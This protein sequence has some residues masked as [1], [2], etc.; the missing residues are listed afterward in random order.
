MF[1]HNRRL[2]FEAKPEKPDPVYAR[3]LLE[4]APS[5]AVTKTAT[6][7]PALGAVLGG[8]DPQ[9]AI[10]AGGG[11]L[12]ADSNGYPWNGRYIVAGG[13]GAEAQ[14]GGWASGPQ[15]DGR[16]RFAYLLDPEPLGDLA[17]APPPDPK[18]Y[19]TYDGSVGEPKSPALGTEVGPVGKLKD[20]LT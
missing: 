8:M 7:D 11:P 16:H 14:A 9:Q 20:K 19:D 4:G 13:D 18:L 12:P 1:R 10:V 5:T 17:M 3:K 15:P 6:A 2:Q